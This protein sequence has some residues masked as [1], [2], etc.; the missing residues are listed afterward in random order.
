MR[1]LLSVIAVLVG[2]IF[3]IPL[4]LTDL[5]REL[6]RHSYHSPPDLD[7]GDDGDDAL[8]EI[9]DPVPPVVTYTE[10]WPVSRYPSA[11]TQGE[12]IHGSS[13]ALDD[14]RSAL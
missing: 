11:R 6:S 9:D 1:V 14:L 10:R 5:A 4:V 8:N 7:G 12:K 13:N 2:A 3:I